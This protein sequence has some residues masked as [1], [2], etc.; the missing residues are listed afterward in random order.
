MKS[1]VG[2]GV[3]HHLKAST[4][5]VVAAAAVVVGAAASSSRLL[6]VAIDACR[7]FDKKLVVCRQ[8]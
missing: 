1:R 8:R 4:V 2:L 6:L 3:V 7:C 5:V